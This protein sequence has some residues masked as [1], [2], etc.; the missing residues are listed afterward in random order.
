M[1]THDSAN[2]SSSSGSKTIAFHL[3]SEFSE[4]VVDLI[5]DAADQ[6][7]LHLILSDPT[8]DHWPLGTSQVIESLKRWA[9][10]HRKLTLLA[11]TFDAFE[12]H[13]PLWVQWRKTWSHVVDCRVADE[14]DWN[15]LPSLLI[16]S[17]I[18]GIRRATV[19]QWRG[20][21]YFEKNDIDRCTEMVDAAL[22]RSTPGYPVTHLG[23]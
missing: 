12:Q 4:Q 8:F 10:P 11:R 5:K 9:L 23:L 14:Q 15:S 6:G 2:S 13:H 22:Q 3:P 1:N 17:P 19:D 21:R 7:C 20:W 18:G 16:A